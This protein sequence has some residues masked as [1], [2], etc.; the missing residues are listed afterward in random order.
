MSLHL[1]IIYCTTILIASMIPGPSSLLAIRQGVQF[2][3][4]VGTIS[5]LGNVIA[6]LLQAIIAFFIISQIGKISTTL[7]FIIKLIGSAYIIYLG[8]TLLKVHS[9]SNALDDND[10]KKDNNYIKHCFDGFAFAIFNPKAIMFFAALFPQFVDGGML[11]LQNIL[12]IFVP[13]GSIAFVCFMV[14]VLAGSALFRLFG[15]SPHIGK[16]FGTSIILAGLAL[17]VS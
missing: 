16:I 8:I 2:G 12:L 15:A 4:V 1:L 10:N 13:I 11:N 7:L 17:L 14:Y 9:F 6:S 3:M 5:A